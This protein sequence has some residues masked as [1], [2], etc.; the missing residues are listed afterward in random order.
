M[1]KTHLELL[2]SGINHFDNQRW[3]E[4]IKDFSE[5]SRL[6]PENSECLA[7]LAFGLAVKD[8]TAN[9]WNIAN[10]AIQLDPN[11]TVAY[12]ARG[13]VHRSKG[14]Y[15]NAI[16]DFSRAIEL[17]PDNSGPYADRAY[18]Y[19]QHKDYAKAL[20]DY[21]KAINLNPNVSSSFYWRGLTH[22][23]MNDFDNYCLDL[24]RYAVRTSNSH[25][26]QWSGQNRF[27]TWYETIHNHV[28]N[29]VLSQL[30]TDEAVVQYFPSLFSWGKQSEVVS[31]RGTV[32]TK[33]SL[34]FGTGYVCVTT[35]NLHLVSLGTLSQKFRLYESDW[36]ASY[37]Q[38]AENLFEGGLD[39]LGQLLD[40]KYHERQSLY[41][42]TRAPSP[43]EKEQRI[44]EKNDQIWVVPYHS[45]QSAQ[46]VGKYI[47]LTTPVMTW[48]IHEHFNNHLRPI[49][50]AIN[51]GAS[52]KYAH[53]WDSPEPKQKVPAQHGADVVTLLKQLSELKAQGVITEVEFEQKK[54]ELLARL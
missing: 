23:A 31:S 44:L 16:R 39:V 10:R 38:T 29:S 48:E 37:E 17:D 40:S 22:Y 8:D 5:A 25:L 2:E 4:A 45:M 32:F 7:W 30:A 21:S 53:L 34:R 50:A 11:S 33:T 52:G 15:S 36:V 49:W 47:S 42:P 3:D 14:D 43:Q 13:Y 6:E 46:I 12:R 28:R 54:K 26:G 20:Q 27:K 1:T 18:A 9:A 41:R 19:Y 51:M 24:A 35:K